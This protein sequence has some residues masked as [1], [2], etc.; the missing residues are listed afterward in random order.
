MNNHVPKPATLNTAYSI[1]IDM[2]LSAVGG[3]WQRIIGSAGY[4]P[5]P[6]MCIYI[7]IYTYIYIYIYIY[8]HIHIYIYTNKHICMYIFIHVYICVYMYLSLYIKAY[9]IAIDMQLSAVGGGWQRIIGSAG[10]PPT[11]NM[12]IHIHTYIHTYI[13][14]HI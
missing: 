14:I 2:Q 13:S 10:C 7:N 5:T 6:N 1:S 8:I 9:S 3:G 4:S 12:C 11:P